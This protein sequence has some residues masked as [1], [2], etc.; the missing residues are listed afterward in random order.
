MN[1]FEFLLK[2]YEFSL[3]KKAFSFAANPGHD[4][5]PGIFKGIFNIAVFGQ[6]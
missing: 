1:S 3:A 5:H 2:W 6:C 4:P